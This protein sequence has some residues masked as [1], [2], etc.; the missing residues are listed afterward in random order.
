MN[1]LV[2][3]SG[4]VDSVV[5]LD[6]MHRV[7]PSQIVVAHF[8]HGIREDSAED[9]KFVKTLAAQYD[10]PYVSKREVLG[11][12]ASEQLARARRYAFLKEQA[13]KHNAKIVTGHHLD[14]LVESVAI[15]LHRG[16]G[17][18]GVAVFG[19]NDVSR[20]LVHMPK[21]DVIKYAKQ[22]GLQWREDSTNAS[23][24]YLRNQLRTR[25]KEL[26]VEQKRQI[27]ALQATQKH[28]KEEIF[29]EAVALIGVGPEY[30]RYLFVHMPIAVAIECLR[31]VTRHRL[32]RPQL[33]RML[34]VIKTASPNSKFE[35]GMGITVHFSTR[36]F[37]V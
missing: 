37:R 11:K 29:K 12:S 25:T 20:P 13:K 6:M 31:Y 5:L 32:T 1:Y 7:A 9:E 21:I 17:W 28:L 2:A 3:V 18:R 33:E 27:H 23:T 22:R 24:K 4:G 36:Y 26:T 10:V 16:T 30:S 14:D 35:A 19:A 34:H 8:D 15:N